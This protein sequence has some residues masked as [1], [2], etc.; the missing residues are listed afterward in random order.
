MAGYDMATG[1]GTPVA[2]ELA[3]GLTG[4]PLDVVV[5]GTQ[6]YG[7]TPTF[8]A[9][10]NYAGS[11]SAP[12]GVTLNTSG[13]SLHRGRHVHDHQPRPWPS[14]QYTLLASSCSGL[15]LSGV[16]AGDYAVVYTSDGERLHGQSRPRRRRRVGQPELRWHAD[17]R[18]HGQPASG[19]TVSTTGLSCTKVGVLT[20][21]PDPG[22]RELRAVAFVVQR[23][24]T[25]GHERRR[26][27]DRLHAQPERLHGDPG[28]A[29][30]HGLERLH[31]LRRHL[32]TITPAYSGFVN[33]NTASSLTT[34]PTCST[35]ATSSSPVLGSPYASSCGGA[36]DPNYAFSY[37][38]GSVTVTPA[39]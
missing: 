30:G 10:A 19:I 38:D 1:L 4:I 32:P 11:G 22:G 12:F 34:Q 27:H 7:G 37:L 33:G 21:R 13:L 16:D 35:A 20:H 24:D 26:L 28:P 18:G 6:A 25:L 5:S 3:I 2:S 36:V 9:S 31:E 39:R 14:G 8:T 15:T 23:G 17:L 29:D